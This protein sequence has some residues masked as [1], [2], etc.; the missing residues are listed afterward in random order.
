MGRLPIGESAPLST[1]DEEMNLLHRFAYLVVMLATCG[2]FSSASIIHLE[3]VE[4][5]WVGARLAKGLLMLAISLFLF[6][7]ALL[8]LDTYGGRV[9]PFLSM[10]AMGWWLY[11]LFFL[12][13]ILSKE[14]APTRVHDKRKPPSGGKS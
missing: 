6:L 7:G 5:I 4:K 3:L 1:K 9:G 14:E 8:Y 2:Y 11:W 10:I 13:Q 12:P